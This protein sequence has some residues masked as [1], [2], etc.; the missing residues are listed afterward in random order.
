MKIFNSFQITVLFAILPFIIQWCSEATF[1]GHSA[2]FWVADAA[3]E[4]IG[5][6]V[7]LDDSLLDRPIENMS[8]ANETRAKML[9][10]LR[11]EN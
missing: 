5:K 9:D 4:E 1:K 8:L 3:L 11:G 10:A 2:A 6:P 7:S